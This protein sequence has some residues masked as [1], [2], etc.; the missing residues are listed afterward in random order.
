MLHSLPM[1]LLG[2][3]LYLITGEGFLIWCLGR[4]GR[5]VAQFRQLDSF[6]L[7]V[8]VVMVSIATWPMAFVLGRMR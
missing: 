7:A 1:I 8:L 5:V 2:L 4:N 6:P 3:K